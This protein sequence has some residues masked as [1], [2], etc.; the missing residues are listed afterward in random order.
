M[1][2]G[3]SGLISI[4][5]KVLESLRLNPGLALLSLGS[6]CV[7]DDIGGDLGN[8]LDLDLARIGLPCPG[9]D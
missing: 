5:L 2:N 7:I 8:D 4:L 1:A 3:S 9:K 6:K